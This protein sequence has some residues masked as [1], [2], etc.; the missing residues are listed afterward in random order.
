M[1]FFST[2]I[3]ISILAAI[4]EFFLPWWTIAVVAFIVSLVTALRPGK[5]FLAGFLGIMLFWLVIIVLR[6]IPNEH[7]LSRRM[8]ELFHL[9]GY[10]LFI[11]VTIFI[12]GIV[13]GLSALSGALLSTRYK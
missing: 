10:G 1:R 6:D 13:G 7:I 8:A 12:G 9:P 11:L 3:S 5:A 4:V 2:L